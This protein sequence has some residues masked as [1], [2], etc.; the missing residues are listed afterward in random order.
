MGEVYRAKDV[1]LG[2]EVAVK[3]LPE[4]I[5]KDADALARFEQEARLLAAISHPNILALHDIGR[6][7]GVAY[8]VTELLEGETLRESLTTGVPAARPLALRSREAEALT[9]AHEKGIVHRD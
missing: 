7:G 2:R 3:V 8:A 6:E 4:R 5:A 1:R 9:A